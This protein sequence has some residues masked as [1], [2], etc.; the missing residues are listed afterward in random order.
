M[1][2]AEVRDVLW[3][4]SRVG[5]LTLLGAVLALAVALIL[6]RVA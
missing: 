2:W 1:R 6:V 4:T 5:A 3:L